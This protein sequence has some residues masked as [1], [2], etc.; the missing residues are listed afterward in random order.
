MVA[1]KGATKLV[2]KGVT[3]YEAPVSTITGHSAASA[4]VY[5]L[6]D[7]E[8]AWDDGQDH[9]DV[10][11]LVRKHMLAVRKLNER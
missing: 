7:D 3:P 1:C 8:Y 2:A 9:V 11:K 10:K 5:P 4:A 6:V